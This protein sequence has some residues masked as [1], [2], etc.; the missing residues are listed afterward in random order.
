MQRRS[1]IL[2]ALLPEL[3][4]DGRE[5]PRGLNASSVSDYA[6]VGYK[7]VHVRCLRRDG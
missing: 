3:V 5:V 6:G 7:E 2:H 4:V 1:E